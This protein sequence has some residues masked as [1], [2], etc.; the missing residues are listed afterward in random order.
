MLH[1]ILATTYWS[2]DPNQSFADPWLQDAE[3]VAYPT[4]VQVFTD[5]WLAENMDIGPLPRLIL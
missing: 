3:V 1:F 2:R 4:D 5:D